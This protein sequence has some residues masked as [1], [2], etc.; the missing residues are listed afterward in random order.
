MALFFHPSKSL[1]GNKTTLKAGLR[2]LFFLLKV[3]VEAGG[4]L[5]NT[6]RM[7]DDEVDKKGRAPHVCTMYIV[8]K[9]SMHMYLAT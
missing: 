7:H 8:H 4:D 5:H 6:S 3:A 9:C 2:V 1:V